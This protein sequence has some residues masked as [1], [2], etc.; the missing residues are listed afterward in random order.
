MAL[1]AA[2]SKVTRRLQAARPGL[3]DAA[4]LE[5]LVAYFSDQVGQRVAPEPRGAPRPAC[6]AA[7]RTETAGRPPLGE[8]PRPG[9]RRWTPALVRR[10]GPQAGTP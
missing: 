1:L 10:R 9:T 7:C 2:R 3:T 8:Q 5:K 6:A 4:V